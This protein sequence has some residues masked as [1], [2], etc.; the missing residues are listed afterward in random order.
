MS[1]QQTTLLDSTRQI[2]KV[3]FDT[4]PF[5]V[6]HNLIKAKRCQSGIIEAGADKV[7]S[8]KLIF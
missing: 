6:V 8:I 2:K 3:Y 4:T 1:P 5:E 7:L